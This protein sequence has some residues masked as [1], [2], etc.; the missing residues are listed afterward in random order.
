MAFSGCAS[1]SSKTICHPSTVWPTPAKDGLG[2]SS[3][4]IEFVLF[5]NGRAT[6]KANIHW[7]PASLSPLLGESAHDH[8]SML[9]GH[10]TQTAGP[11][12]NLWQE[13]LAGAPGGACAGHWAERVKG[14]WAPGVASCYTNTNTYAEKAGHEHTDKNGDEKSKGLTEEE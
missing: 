13:S 7:G 11:V 6:L 8:A 3:L 2:R 10:L 9:W 4:F 12:S 5:I 1:V 14:S